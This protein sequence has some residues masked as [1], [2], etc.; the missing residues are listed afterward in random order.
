MPCK[1]PEDRRA[2]DAA[3]RVKNKERIKARNVAW[4]KTRNANPEY[5]EYMKTY[6]KAYRQTPEYKARNRARMKAYYATPEGNIYRKVYEAARY[7]IPELREKK[8]AYKIARQR[9]SRIWGWGG[10]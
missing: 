1:N 4:R 8:I 5:R 7:A 10:V 2:Y 3:Y 6:L 9:S